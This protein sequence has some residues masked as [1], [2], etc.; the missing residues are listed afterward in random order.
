MMLLA[1]FLA[2]PTVLPDYFTEF[3]SRLLILGLFALSF[4]LVFGFAGIMSF[5]QAL[6]FGGAGYVVALLARD[7]N[8]SSV[9]VAVP[10]SITVGLALAAAVAAF[11]ML[12]GHPPSTIFV[13]LGT[14]TASFAGE[15]L[16]RSWYYLGGQNGIPS[17]PQLSAF[18][19][20]FTDLG[21]H[22]TVLAIFV[23]VYLGCRA[24]VRS[25]FGL[26]LIGIREQ[27][28][29]LGFFGYRAPVFKALVFSVAG[30]VA[31]LAGGLYAYQQGFVWPSM[32]GVVLSTQIVLY[33][34]FGGIG[35]LVGSALGVI[36]IESFGYV[37]SDQF[38]KIWPILLGILLL[39]VIL[40]RP[41]GIVSLFVSDRERLGDFRPR[42]GRR[43]VQIAKEQDAVT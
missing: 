38:P 13:A 7:F 40:L 17:I 6:F 2:V 5:G 34:L 1:V 8:V 33:C 37:F 31:G 32:I 28:E 18:G 12:G 21:F 35:T 39:L 3:A 42:P 11:L 43:A 36:A 24:L 27:E 25:Q 29:R 26:A 19:Y 41:S 23:L 4:D 30:A 10:V 16:A 20:P 9:F 14:L 22:Y 15:E